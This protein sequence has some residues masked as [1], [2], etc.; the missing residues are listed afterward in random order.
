MGQA[1]NRDDRLSVTLLSRRT[2]G[3]N[4]PPERCEQLLD[5]LD[6][7]SPADGVDPV[8]PF[9]PTRNQPRAQQD[10]QVPREDGTVLGKLLVEARDVA[11]TA[12]QE[13][14][15]HFQ[16][17]R[18]GERPE[19]LRVEDFERLSSRRCARARR[20]LPASCFEPCHGRMH[21]DA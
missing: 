13:N 18:L 3:R 5:P 14:A 1:C 17:R 21:T 12:H 20:P 9:A 7:N 10:L 11:G 15:Q 16:P 4:D 2:A 19:K 8:P 6:K